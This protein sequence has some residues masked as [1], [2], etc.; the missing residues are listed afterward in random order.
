MAVVESGMSVRSVIE[1][2]KE[3]LPKRM[4][5]DSFEA[6]ASAHMTMTASGAYDCLDAAVAALEALQ[7]ALKAQRCAVRSVSMENELAAQGLSRWMLRVE[8]RV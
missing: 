5:I 6:R 8:I 2:V 7:S 1:K 4:S 3:T